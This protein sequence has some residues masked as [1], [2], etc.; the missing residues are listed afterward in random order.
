MDLLESYG[1]YTGS[2]T[3]SIV[4]ACC[5]VYADSPGVITATTYKTQLA[6]NLNI[7]TV[8]TQ[9]AGSISSIALIELAA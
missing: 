5:V 8:Y 6:S 3:S 7:G 4:G 9:I 1:G 2:A